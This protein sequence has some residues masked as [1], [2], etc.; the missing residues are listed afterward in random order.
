MDTLWPMVVGAGTVEKIIL[1]LLGVLS[2]VLWS[3]V[4]L[5]VPEIL[6]AKRNGARFLE[7]FR[8][9][10]DFGE[11]KALEFQGDCI[12]HEVFKSALAALNGKPPSK[13]PVG[14]SDPE[15]FRIAPDSST[16]EIVLLSMQHTSAAYLLHLQRG[17]SMLA[18]IGSTT[19]FIGLFGTVIGIMST[20]H[21][22]GAV[23]SP[24]MQVVAPGI[25]G[26]LIATAAGLAVAI[27][28]V[29]VCNWFS[30]Q[31]GMIQ[32]SV[33]A[34]IE[35]MMALVRANC[36]AKAEAAEAKAPAVR[37][38]PAAPKV[39]KPHSDVAAPKVRTDVP[40]AV[41][42]RVTAPRPDAAL[43]VEKDVSDTPSTKRPGAKMSDDL[44][45][46]KSHVELAVGKR[47]PKT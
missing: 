20:F 1:V 33:D 17:I 28:A 14:T 8:E 42:R 18:T 2:V 5:K 25:S 3:T 11:V 12:H 40:V 47:M 6:A 39:L 23:K 26:A 35:K 15:R 4:I 9:A 19:P 31:I 45:S 43:A 37:E 27:P 30:S 21:A 7:K 29:I 16:E 44:L 41:P 13:Q 36:E 22:L 34:F 38:T 10:S 32:E 24:S 46:E